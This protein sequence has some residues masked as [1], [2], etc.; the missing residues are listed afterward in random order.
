MALTQKNKEIVVGLLAF[1]VAV[2]G[3]SLVPLHGGDDWEV[4]RQAALRLF[5]AQPL[6]GEPVFQGFYFYN[7]PW[8]A[9]LLSPLALLPSKLGWAFLS[10][11][12]LVL[13]LLVVRRWQAGLIKP[14][15]AILS[16]PM[17]YILL[18]GQVDALVLGG[19]L[20]PTSVWGLV[21]FAKP[22][23]AFGLAFGGLIHRRQLIQLML[24]AVSG[25]TLSLLLFGLWP[26]AILNQP[27]P[28]GD[29]NIW[30]GLWP[31]QV[32][33]GLAILLFGIDRQDE[34][35]LVAASP[36]FLP[37]A[38]T[39]SLLGPWIVTI[40]FLRSWQAGLV[41]AVW[42]AAVVFRAIIF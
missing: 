39:S 31:F 30:G 6:C 36:F 25:L 40:S 7:A 1:I 4:F 29:H 12:S 5:N 13:T 18:H 8:L 14:V 37:Y 20:L 11:A 42:W 22:Q 2:A 3:F 34:R 23:V 10:V 9:V 32:P 21:A 15:L 16:P 35:F 28:V 38:A 26:L 19:I 17:L 41:L 33:V 27:G 24:V